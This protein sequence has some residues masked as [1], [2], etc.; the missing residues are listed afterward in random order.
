MKL[1]F[2]HYGRLLYAVTVTTL[3]VIFPDSRAVHYILVWYMGCVL[4]RVAYECRA[5]YTKAKRWQADLEKAAREYCQWKKENDVIFSYVSA[6][7][8]LVPVEVAKE[9]VEYNCNADNQEE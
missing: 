3:Y 1:W 9:S 7:D 6:I 4:G 2:K 5:E 8:E